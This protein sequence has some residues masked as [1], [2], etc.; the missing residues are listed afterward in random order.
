M[1]KFVLITVLYLMVSVVIMMAGFAM[2][3]DIL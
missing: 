3:S 1:K 2:V